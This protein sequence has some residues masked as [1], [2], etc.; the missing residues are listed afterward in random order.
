MK[1]DSLYLENFRNYSAFSCDFAP[2]VNL[3]LGENAQGKTNLLEAICYLSQGKGFRTRKEA[4]LIRFGADFAQLEGSV[5]GH[6]RQQTLKM[7][8]FSGRRSRQILLN[9]VRKKPRE[10]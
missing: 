6:R 8:L 9:G 10:R 3:I 2:G 4:E 5:T 1:L 7:T